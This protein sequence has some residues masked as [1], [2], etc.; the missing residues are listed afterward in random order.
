[1][2]ALSHSLKLF[3]IHIHV[4]LLFCPCF[5]WVLGKKPFDRSAIQHRPREAAEDP[6][7][8]GKTGES[9]FTLQTKREFHLLLLSPAGSEEPGDRHSAEE[10]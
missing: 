8:D 7:S 5:S 9:A 1:M 3:V 2:C 6:P 10:D 4:P